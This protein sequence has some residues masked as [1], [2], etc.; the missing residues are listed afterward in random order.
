MNIITVDDEELILERMMELIGQIEGVKEINGFRLPN[1]AL[2]FAKEH[3]IDVAFLDIKMR[4]MDGITLAKKLKLQQPEINIIFM[5]GYSDYMLDAFRLHVS[6]YLLKPPSIA[7]IKKE[8]ED[9]RRPVKYEDRKRIVAQC[10]GNFEFYIDGK[11]CAFRYAKTKEL[12]AYLIDRN[13]SLCTNGELMAI[14][15]EDESEGQD[16]Y[17]RNLVSDLRGYFKEHDCEGVLIKKR[18]LLAIV[19]DKIFCD[20]YEW[21]NGNPEVVNRYNGEYMSQYSWAEVTSARIIV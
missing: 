12:L 18:G 6:G 16:A 5:T 2:E 13:G 21:M 14:L 7:D 3:R 15:W 1:Q 11:P 8:L 20:Y 19:P 4:G 10:F 17:L 9:L